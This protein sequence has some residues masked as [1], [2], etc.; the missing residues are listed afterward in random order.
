MHHPRPDIRQELLA[1]FSGLFIFS[2]LGV[3]FTG[4]AVYLRWSLIFV[5][6]AGVLAYSLLDNPPR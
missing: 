1:L 4:S 2:A 5:T 6:I 3:L